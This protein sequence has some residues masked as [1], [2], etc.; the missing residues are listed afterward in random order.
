MGDPSSELIKGRS[1]Q[2]YER[3][4]RIEYGISAL[5]LGLERVVLF[6]PLL[7]FQLPFFNYTRLVAFSFL[8]IGNRYMQQR[9]I[10]EMEYAIKTGNLSIMYDL[11]KYLTGAWENGKE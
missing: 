9:F 1:S 3:R 7:R 10:L 2:F 11:K 4:I 8:V 5:C 6:Y